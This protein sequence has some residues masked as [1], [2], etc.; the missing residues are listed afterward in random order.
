MKKHQN[1]MIG[2]FVFYFFRTWRFPDNEFYYLF[3]DFDLKNHAGE[4]DPVR[5]DASAWSSGTGQGGLG[6]R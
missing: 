4:F 5:P 3:S 2:D 6:E 1:N